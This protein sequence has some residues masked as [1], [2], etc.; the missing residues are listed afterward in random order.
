MEDYYNKTEKECDKWWNSMEYDEKR[1]IFSE[2][3]ES[4]GYTKDKD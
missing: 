2:L 3:H 1:E 4:Y